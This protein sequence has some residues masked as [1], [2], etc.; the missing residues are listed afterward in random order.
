MLDDFVLTKRFRANLPLMPNKQPTEKQLRCMQHVANARRTIESIVRDPYDTGHYV[1]ACQALYELDAAS[2]FT[3][4]D[5]VWT[6][7]VNGGTVANVWAWDRKTVL[8]HVAD[9]KA[10]G[11]AFDDERVIKMAVGAFNIH[12]IRHKLATVGMR[13]RGQ[14]L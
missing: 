8:R 1:N 2:P 5:P 3:A 11:E 13:W 9:R 12:Q 4:G 6:T 10:N 7:V 14:A